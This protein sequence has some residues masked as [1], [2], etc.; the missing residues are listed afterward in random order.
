MEKVIIITP[1]HPLRGGIAASGE[2][3]AQAFQEAGHTVRVYSFSLQYP[4]L[5]F[6][7]KT[8]KT[9]DPAPQNIDIQTVINSINPFN[10]WRVGRAIAAEN[11]DLVICR[12]WLPFM[13]MSLGSILRFVRKNKKTTIIALVDNIVPHEKRAGDHFLAKYFTDAC[14]AFIV[15]SRSVER[16]MADFSKKK[17]LYVPHPIYDTYGEK[18]DRVVALKK[19]QLTENQRY[20]L[21]FGFIRRYKG[22]DL[23]IEAL[24]ILKRQNS[25]ALSNIRLLVAG[26]F[27]ED[28]KKYRDIITAQ[29]LDNEVIIK[30][31]FI[32]SDEV[33]YYFGAADL[34]VQPYRTAT[35]SGISQIA[36]HFEKPMIVTKVGGLPEIVPHGVAGYVVE[37]TPQYLAE[38]IEDFF[39]NN[40]SEVLS[41]GV[42]EQKKRFSWA[43][44][45]ESFLHL[46]TELKRQ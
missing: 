24:G 5:L 30:S 9:D 2:R 34:I 37:P 12:F 7:G 39:K 17:C 45:V 44:M 18:T 35:Q 25:A 19:L 10:W 1:A 38:A 27:Y 23:L 36:Y 6:P 31:D 13:G 33:R 15:M 43:S 46:E 40:R 28:E 20:I 4:S 29:N 16:E 14:D 22:L 3:L 8:Q 21:F 41:R 32:P 11:A 26:E 42:S